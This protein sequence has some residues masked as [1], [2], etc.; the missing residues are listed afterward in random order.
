MVSGDRN[1]RNKSCLSWWVNGPRSGSTLKGTSPA[2]KSLSINVSH[3]L[4]LP[5][6]DSCNS[7]NSLSSV[8]EKLEMPC[9]SG[10]LWWSP[11]WDTEPFSHLTLLI[12]TTITISWW[13][14]LW[15]LPSVLD[16]ERL[17]AVYSWLYQEFR[18]ILYWDATVLTHYLSDCVL[19]VSNPADGIQ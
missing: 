12:I 19:W 9:T 14:R 10:I 13:Q 1:T 17:V 3:S 18:T 7:R 15:G 6:G 2:L 5:S 8:E 4:S 11:L 16:T